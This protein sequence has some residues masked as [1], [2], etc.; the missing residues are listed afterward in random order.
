MCDAR[1][2]HAVFPEA[3]IDDPW[4]LWDAVAPVVSM[5]VVAFCAAAGFVCVGITDYERFTVW[6]V[7][8]I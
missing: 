6:V 5:I 3:G 4:V 2:E 7:L 1:R 8:V